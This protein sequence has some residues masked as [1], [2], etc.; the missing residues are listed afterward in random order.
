MAFRILSVFQ[1]LHDFDEA[2]EAYRN[3]T[4]S[5][6]AISTSAKTQNKINYSYCVFKC[7]HF[8]DPEKKLAKTKSVGKRPK[9]QYIKPTNFP[10]FFRLFCRPD[11]TYQITKLNDKHEGRELNEELF[12]HLLRFLLPF[13]NFFLFFL[14]IFHHFYKFV[15]KVLIL[16]KLLSKCLS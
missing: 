4:Y 14:D 9:Q 11:G 16:Y 8:E 7:I 15:N 5:T 6:F 3:S 10:A 12:K 2:F 13:L 1:T